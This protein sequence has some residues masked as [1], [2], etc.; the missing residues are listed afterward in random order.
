MEMLAVS[1]SICDLRQSTVIFF[2]MA[3]TEFLLSTLNQ[4]DTTCIAIDVE[5]L[6]RET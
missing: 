2:T 4:D 5:N 3:H 6:K 1:G